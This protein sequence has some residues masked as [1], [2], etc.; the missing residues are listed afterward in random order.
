MV[1]YMYACFTISKPPILYVRLLQNLS[2]MNILDPN[3]LWQIVST[4]FAS[5]L[6]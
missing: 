3:F 2:T 4:L 5:D 1:F 6:R